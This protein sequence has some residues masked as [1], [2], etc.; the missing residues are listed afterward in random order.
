MHKD[1][2][3]HA[4]LQKLTSHLSFTRSYL[5]MYSA[6]KSKQTKKEENTEFRKQEI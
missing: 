6:K 3:R 1:I 4:S 5:Q 2:F